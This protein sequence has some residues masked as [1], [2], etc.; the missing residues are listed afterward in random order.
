MADFSNRLGKT[1]EIGGDPWIFRFA[2]GLVVH[3]DPFMRPDAGRILPVGGPQDMVMNRLVNLPQIVEGKRVLDAFA[4][5]GVFG[6]MALRLGAAAV[7]FVDINPRAVRF[8]LENCARNG[9]APDRYRAIQASVADLSNTHAYDLV[10]ANPPFVMTPQGIEGTLTSNAGA[11]G[12]EHTEMLMARLDE[13]LA[14]TG[15]AYVFV[16]QLVADGEPLMVRT[17]PRH[18]NQRAVTLT[19]VQEQTCPFEYYVEAY[20]QRFASKAA[21]VREWEHDLRARLGSDLGVQHYIVRVAPR[22]AG[23][24]TWSIIDNLASDYGAGFRYP[25]GSERDMALGRVTENLILPNPG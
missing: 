7:D 4:G 8:T 24:T 17:L 19:P 10:L 14:E 9:F 5:S 22:G 18:L 11:D 20:L 23:A 16:M 13:L 1:M 2:N 3:T 15:E 12:N 6:L 25:A 21:A